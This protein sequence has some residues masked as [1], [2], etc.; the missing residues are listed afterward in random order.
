MTLNAFE[1][2]DAQIR[3]LTGMTGVPGPLF[4]L[5]RDRRVA[6][7]VVGGMNTAIAS[8]GACSISPASSASWPT[9]STLAKAL[10]C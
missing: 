9:S 1:G 6:L 4:R 3:P 8:T 5:V 10:V 2:N 7:L